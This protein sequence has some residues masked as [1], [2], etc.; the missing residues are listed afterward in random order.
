MGM[1][2]VVATFTSHL[3]ASI[4]IAVAV[5][6]TLVVVTTKGNMTRFK[7]TA[8]QEYC[9]AEY[10]TGDDLAIS[11]YAGSGKTATLVLLSEQDQD[12]KIGFIAF[13]KKIATSAGKKFPR[14]VDC[15]TAHSH[16]Y[17]A[18]GKNYED[19]LNGPK[20]YAKQHARFLGIRS[21]LEVGEDMVLSPYHLAVQVQQT[22]RNFCYSAEQEIDWMHVPYLPG[23]NMSILRPY[24]VPLARRMWEDKQLM[25]G[26]CAYTH[27]DYFK[28]WSLSNPRLPYD[29]V[30]VDEAQDSNPALM[31][32]VSASA[33]HRR[34]SSAT[35]TSRSTP[36]EERSMP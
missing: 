27:D 34:S 19:R 13:N 10:A 28:M 14:N 18:V 2:L 35:P 6:K 33:R 20:I 31:T 5:D 12:S 29:V 8:E 17:R 25:Q 4:V 3:M 21:G 16:A 26:Q 32:V 36:G 15:R 9:S 23:A 1:S 24:L 22:V 7:P 11:A 30:M